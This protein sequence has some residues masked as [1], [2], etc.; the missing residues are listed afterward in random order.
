MSLPLSFQQAIAEQRLFTKADRLLLAVSGG[1]DSIV[2]CELCRQAGFDFIIAHCNFQLRGAESERDEAFVKT[3]A[4]RYGVEV[5]VKRFDT[6]AYAAKKKR[7]IQVAAR[8]L[9]YEWFEQLIGEQK[10][11]FLLTAHHADDNA[12]TV[13]MNFCRGTGLP[14]LTGIPAVSGNIR[15]PLL[16]FSKEELIAFANANGLSFV[17][18]SSNE[19][20][21]YTRNLFRN[22]I[23]PLIARAYPQVTA[24]L[25]DTIRRFTGIE[26]LYRYAT[27]EIKKKLYR[28][29]GNEVHIPIRQLLSFNNRALVYEIISSF[30]FTEKQVDEVLKLTE[31]ESGSYIQSPGAAYRIIRHRHWLLI[32]P[33]LSA[34][35]DNI[36]IEEKDRETVFSGGIL[37]VANEEARADSKPDTSPHI[38]CLDARAITFPLLL[39]RWKQGDYFYPLGMAKKKKLSRF[40]IDQKM[41]KTDKETVWVLEMNK[42]IVWVVGRR[43]DNRFKVTDD[44]KRCLTLT[45]SAP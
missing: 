39:R 43:I 44:T 36:I 12:E 8:E 27:G 18:D 3:L 37:T 2:L 16:R 40:F 17:E 5:L 25:Q 6:E 14:G 35:A 33:V 19:S 34:A 20:S 41:S 30:G 45:F 38:A 22:E 26:Q 10:A 1:V 42:K 32:S 15:R 21:K 11:G 23:I 4:D 13:L 29:K 31:S 9:R 24:N 28:H 7:S